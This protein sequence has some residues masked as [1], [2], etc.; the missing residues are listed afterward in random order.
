M[1]FRNFTRYRGVGL[2]CAAAVLLMGCASKPTIYTNADPAADMSQFKTF[3]FAPTL[4]TDRD[5]GTRSLLSKYLEDAITREMTQRGYSPVRQNSDLLVNVFVNTNE[6]ISSRSVPTSA[7]YYDYRRG[8][9]GTWGGYGGYETQ[10]TQYTE[11]T[12]HLELVDA[13]R[14]QL[15]WEGIMVGRIT[16][17]V[18]EN[19][20]TAVDRAIPELMLNYPYVAGSGTPVTNEK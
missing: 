16:D 17:E 8:Y 12:L 10:I 7:G 6:K 5:S 20:Q 1:R 15:V 3:A 9:Y 14:K 13:K 2:V 18:R 11:G 4:G 19:L